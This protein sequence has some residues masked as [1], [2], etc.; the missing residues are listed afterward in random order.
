[1]EIYVVAGFVIIIVHYK[2]S[3]WV[4]A[5]M[6]RVGNGSTSTSLGVAVRFGIN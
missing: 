5:I 2:G 6:L 1:M 4:P 3:A